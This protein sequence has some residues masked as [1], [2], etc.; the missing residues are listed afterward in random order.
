[1]SII[2]M[3]TQ[4]KTKI[5]LMKYK[6]KSFLMEK[7][8][9]TPA[10]SSKIKAKFWRNGKM[11]KEKKSHLILQ[12]VSQVTTKKQLKFTQFSKIK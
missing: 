11:K 10:M 2:S 6:N 8:Y 5:Q 4:L 1:M 9:L 7:K 12:S 3:I